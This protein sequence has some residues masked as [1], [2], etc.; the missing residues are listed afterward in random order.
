MANI[1]KII[2]SNEK[3]LII[4]DFIPDEM[5][6]IDSSGKF[7]EDFVTI[8][9]I[10]YT[11]KKKIDFLSTNTLSG[12]TSKAIFKKAKE[13]GVEY[14]DINKNLTDEEKL[15]IYMG[16]NLDSKESEN[17]NDITLNIEKIKIEYGIDKDKHSFT[18]KDGKKIELNFEY[19]SAIG[20]EPLIIYIIKQIDD[21]SNNFFFK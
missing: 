11:I 7:L 13:K 1:N 17:M 3:K 14:K 15:D 6:D 12:A 2:E 4:S 18:D 16:L 9:K 10:S 20:N 19:L 8:K 21:F 5:K